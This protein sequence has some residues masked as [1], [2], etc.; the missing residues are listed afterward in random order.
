MLVYD[1]KRIFRN[2]STVFMYILSPLIVILLFVSVVF[3]LLMTSKNISFQI[4]IYNEDQ[5]D[6]TKE[7]V[8]QYVNSYA[9]QNILTAYP[10]QSIEQ[11]RALV[12]EDKVSA[13][14]HVPDQLYDDIVQN[15]NVNVYVYG[16]KEHALEISLV[17]MTMGSAL[18]IVNQSEKNF[19]LT[20][21]ILLENSRNYEAVNDYLEEK[22]QQSIQDFMNRRSIVGEVG[23]STSIREYLPLE[24]SI[25]ALFT[26]FATLAILPIIQLN[27]RDFNGSV[28]KRGLLVGKSWKEFIIS[29]IC[30]GSILVIFV[31]AMLIPTSLV[32]HLKIQMI[33]FFDGRFWALILSMIVCSLVHSASALCISAWIKN[34]KSALWIGF[35]Y[36]FVSM[37]CS[38]I[39][40]PQGVLPKIISDLGVILPTRYFMRLLTGA[41]F[42][43]EAR[44]YIQSLLMM[45]IYFIIMMVLGVIGLNRR[46]YR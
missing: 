14:V 26:L 27:V 2:K 25:G 24:Y 12:D 37:I 4:A 42:Q 32:L 38:G 46:D 28:L 9:V 30:S 20:R 19:A 3:P 1:L 10:V 36:I 5:S 18:S 35:Y 7:F 39:L 22:M 41:L 34:E 11:G 40:I 16:K 21:K 23:I 33:G 15:Q 8:Q 31:S 29:R 17:E 45:I 44:S 13:F 43:F 6:V